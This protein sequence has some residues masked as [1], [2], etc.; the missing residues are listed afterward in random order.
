M[1]LRDS[2]TIDYSLLRTPPGHGDVLVVPAARRWNP[3]ARENAARLSF[4]DVQLIGRPLREWRQRAREALVG[5]ER[6]ARPVVVLGHQPEFIHPGVWAKHVAAARFAGTLGGT[7]L[8]LVVD[9]DEAKGTVLHVPCATEQ[10]ITLASIR[11]AETSSARTYEQLAALS[12]RAL[13]DAS[14]RTRAALAERYPATPMP[15]FLASAGVSGHGDWVDQMVAGRQAM[16]A[17]FGI[18]MIEKR[19]STLWWTPLVADMLLNGPRF[20][21]AYN[22]ALRAYRRDQ[23]VRD[24]RRPMPD[25]ELHGERAELPLWAVAAAGAARRRVLV[26]RSGDRVRLFA[27]GTAIGDIRAEELA[28]EVAE[29]RPPA[30]LGSRQLRPRALA[31]TLWARLLVADWFVHGIGG[32]KYDRINDAIMT[33]YYGI[34]PPHMACV[35]AT[36]HLGLP[37]AEITAQ[38]VQERRRRVRDVH[39]NPQRYVKGAG[40]VARLVARREQAV[41]RAVELAERHAG[42]RSARRRC[43][44]E[45]RGITEALR[46]HCGETLGRVEAEWRSA[47]RALAARR[48]AEGREYFFGLYPRGAL[49]QMMAALPAGG[50]FGV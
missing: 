23:G 12:E 17:S 16:D 37:F 11:W 39:W 14:Q 6:A 8:N 49:E 30:W 34:A 36:L 48:L 5:A 31:L 35:S 38:D 4:N 22:R 21:A 40:E 46:V 15:L 43:F 7:A 3:L 24:V 45:I 41:A 20:A 13:A 25:L 33:D 26:E 27:E 28:L 32:A 29:D 47:E 10:G 9:S 50:D 42:D 44:E 1:P 19:V 2:A 18:G